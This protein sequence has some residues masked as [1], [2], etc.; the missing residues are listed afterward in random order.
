MGQET[1]MNR[2][3]VEVFHEVLRREDAAIAA[4]GVS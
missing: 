4:A 1:I 3:L 2:F